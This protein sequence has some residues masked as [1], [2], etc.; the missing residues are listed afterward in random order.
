M[1]PDVSIVYVVTSCLPSLIFVLLVEVSRASFV[2]MCAIRAHPYED[3][4]LLNKKH[5]CSQS[6]Y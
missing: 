1:L 3:F 2:G 5:S 6:Y 4:E